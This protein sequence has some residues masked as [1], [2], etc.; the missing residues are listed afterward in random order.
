LTEGIKVRLASISQDPDG[1]LC[2]SRA[3]TTYQ[4][5]ARNLKGQVPM[6]I[7][8]H[9]NHMLVSTFDKE[10]EAYLKGEKSLRNYKRNIP[11]PFGPGDVRLFK[12]TEDGKNFCFRFFGL[13]LRTYLGK[14][15]TD[16]RW[17]LQKLAEGKGELR[18][19]ALKIDGNKLYWLAAFVSEREQHTLDESVLA[20]VSLSLDYPLTVIIGKLRFTI[21]TKDEFLYRRLAIQA[22][23]QRAMHQASCSRGGKGR[24][25]K[26]KSIETYHEKERRY[27]SYRLHQYSRRL[28]DLCTRHSAGTILLTGQQEK[29]EAAKDS[30][31]VLRNWS[32]HGLKEK[33]SY[34]AARAGINL[35][36]E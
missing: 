24:R 17:L 14:D 34:K 19:S 35:V 33:I 8:N 20:E 15:F 29:E 2:S 5:L 23:R 22:A 26:L 3:N 4:V 12:P 16:K 28:V 6:T 32:Y 36:V 11:I 9:L 31:F 13:P 25:R 10:R 21:G 27:I 1:I 30:S 7:L 18:T